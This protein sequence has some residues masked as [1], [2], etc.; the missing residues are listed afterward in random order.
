MRSRDKWEAL[1]KFE[2]QD[3]IP[4]DYMG[5][6]ETDRRLK[7][8][9]GVDTEVELLDILGSDFF[10]LP[11]RDLSQREGFMKYYNKQLRVDE[12]ERTC[13]LGIRW[14]REVGEHKFSVDEAISSPLS[15]LKTTAQLEEYPWP[16][17]EDFDFSP[18]LKECDD[19][20]E[21]IIVGGFWTGIM[22]DSY[23]L[24]GFQN[25]LLNI[26]LQPEL[27]G[28]L[29]DKLTDVYFDLNRALFETLQGKM[30]VWFFGNDFGGQNGLLISRE[31]WRTFFFKNIKKLT[32]LAH[33]YGLKVMMHSCGAIIELI[34][35]LIESGVDIL[36]PVQVSADGMDLVRLKEDFGKKIIFHGGVDTQQLL[37][38]GSPQD[39]RMAVE[40]IKRTLGFTGGY[41]L[42]GSQLL[43]PDIPI[44][45]ILSMYGISS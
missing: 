43:G 7:E 11:C 25:F 38:Y 12:T 8:Y 23:R 3:C 28:A 1:C 35:D 31:M 10:Y 18:L 17:P 20:K 37:P 30:D 22:G 40:D 36:D 32:G 34:P 16:V 27:I 19:N 33:D 29:I 26:A 2:A 15:D 41:I 9:F 45:N 6:Y 4:V 24:H 42:A 13:A 39:V 44:E 5:H 21:R 14:Q